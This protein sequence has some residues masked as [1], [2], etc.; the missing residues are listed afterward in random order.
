M[1]LG[2]GDFVLLHL[3]QPSEKFWGVLDAIE[4]VGVSI[5]GIGL[6]SFDEWSGEIARRE[7]P[8]LGLVTMFVPLFRVE[9]VFLDERVGEVESYRAR[10]ARRV[11]RAV[12]EVLGLEP[13]A[14]TDSGP[15]S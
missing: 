1:R 2:R 14:E 4:P 15:P 8:T 13:P 5:R 12:E 9:R 11:G 3:I 6:E 7:E 10:F